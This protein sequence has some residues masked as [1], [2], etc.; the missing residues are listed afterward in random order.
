MVVNEED[1]MLYKALHEHSSL[2]LY[3]FIF[4]P[5]KSIVIPGTFD[6]GGTFNNQLS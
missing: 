2:G 4:L 6:D 1:M 5:D 3:P